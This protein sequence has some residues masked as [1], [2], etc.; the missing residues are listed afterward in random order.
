MANAASPAARAQAVAA[1][2]SLGLCQQ[3]AEAAADLGWKSPTNVQQQAVPFL[4]QGKGSYSCFAVC[5]FWFESP[6]LTQSC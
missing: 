2:E 5:K 4:I 3:L 6:F 1:F